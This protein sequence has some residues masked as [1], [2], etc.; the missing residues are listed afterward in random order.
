MSA[1][2]VALVVGTVLAIGALAYVLYP[3][4]F[5]ALDTSA[6]AP[7]AV[8]PASES[9]L[10]VAA[11][12]EIE[13]DRATGKLSDADYAQLK[14]RYTREALA[15]MRAADRSGSV[16]TGVASGAP[17]DEVEAA[18]I[19]WRARHPECV[20]CG[21]RPEPDAIFCSTCGR[22]LR[23]ACGRCGARIDEVGARFCRQCGE[24]LAA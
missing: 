11:L 15:A 9:N 17:D 13:F 19:D 3:I 2:I 5:P 23:G 16:M 21:P 12:R 7:A 4:F 6:G 20:T 10:A 18:I 1:A 22:Y 8:A 24:R 14:E